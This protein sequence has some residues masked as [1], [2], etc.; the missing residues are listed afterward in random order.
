MGDTKEPL[1][2]S[3]LKAWAGFRTGPGVIGRGSAV[4]LGTIPVLMI[5]A[6]KADTWWM[7]A[8]VL[9][10]ALCVFAG[11]FFPAQR[12]AHKNPHL[13]LLE[14]SQLLDLRKSEM[15][16]QGQIKPET[17]NVL[18]KEIIDVPQGDSDGR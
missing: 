17:P 3:W 6:W 10:G 15:A 12:F 4:A 16:I 11:F 7:Q 1:D 2:F 9:L 8:L 13:A 18:A 5:L 14:G